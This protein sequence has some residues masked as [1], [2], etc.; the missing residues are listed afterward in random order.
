MSSCRRPTM[1]F[2]R[3]RVTIASSVV[4]SVKMWGRKGGA[5]LS[6][7]HQW[8]RLAW[9]ALLGW[10]RCRR[11]RG[12]FCSGILVS[13]EARVIS[14]GSRLARI[15]SRALQGYTCGSVVQSSSHGGR[16]AGRRA[17]PPRPDCRS[18]HRGSWEKGGLIF[19]GPRSVPAR[20]LVLGL[21]AFPLHSSSVMHAQT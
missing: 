8:W 7:C 18:K 5:G 14:W 6:R 17:R 2:F 11:G 21:I 1:M 3:C 20:G 15:Q 16:P 4:C 10:Q 12:D 9:H 13:L 19:L